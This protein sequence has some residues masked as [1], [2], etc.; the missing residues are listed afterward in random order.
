[1][2]YSSA[3]ELPSQFDNL[4][5]NARR[6]AMHVINSSLEK[7]LSEERAFK[8][9]WGAIKEKYK[10]SGDKWVVKSFVF[11]SQKIEFKS[12][13]GKFCFEGYLENFKE[14]SVGDVCTQNCLLDM[15]SQISG[16]KAFVKGDFDHDVVLENDP[17]KIPISKINSAKVDSEGLWVQ[18]E[19][20]ASHSDFQKIWKMSQDGFLDGLSI[21]YNVEQFLPR[22]NGGRLLNKINLKG[23][24]HTPRPINKGCRLTK[25]FAKS[26]S[27]D[28][29]DNDSKFLDKKS[30]IGDDKMGEQTEVKT[31]I[32]T[33]KP[34][35]KSEDAVK[36][37]TEI[38]AKE[39]L[40]KEVTELKAK[41]EDDKKKYTEMK[42]MVKEILTEIKNESKVLT[43]SEPEIKS[44]PVSFIGMF[45]K[46]LEK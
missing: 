45:Q 31:E 38:K 27:V 4:P 20:N 10:K 13:E 2:P 43:T 26:L 16:L 35:I 3:K 22:E 28:E 24:A 14:D 34:E 5:E 39:A 32:K 46:A 37:E 25:V 36:L 15:C 1:M 12:A 44:E 8:S 40:Q 19:F 7:G 17:M 30:E 9:A 6:M 11:D 33:E 23:Y 41:V 42:G 21:E 18:G 29:D